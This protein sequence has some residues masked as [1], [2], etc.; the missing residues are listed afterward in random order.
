VIFAGGIL[1]IELISFGAD[2]YVHG[3]LGDD[4]VEIIP[5]AFGQFIQSKVVVLRIVVK[6]AETL[7]IGSG[8]QLTAH[9]FLRFL[10]QHL[11]G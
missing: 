10:R 1:K 3:R 4:D 11:A 6:E 7:Y 5:G 9:Q 8:C 2:I